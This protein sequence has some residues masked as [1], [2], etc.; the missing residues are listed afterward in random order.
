M[1]PLAAIL[2]TGHYVPSRVMTNADLEKIVETSDE[3]IRSRTGIRERRIAAADEHVSDMATYAGKAALESAG[4]QASE[5]DLIILATLTP[6]YTWPAAACLVQRKLGAFRAS[7]FDISA[8]CSGF[9]YGISLAQAMVAA[10]T[11]KNILVIGA[12]KLSAVVD[13]KDR[14]TCVLFGDGAG[15]VV[16]GP[17]QGRGAILSTHLGTDGTAVELLYQPGGGTVCPVSPE[18]LAERKHFLHMNGKEVYKFAVK[19]MGEAAE[20]AMAKAGL[21]S[22]D[23]SLFIPH[24]ANI[25]IIEAAAKRLELPMEKVFINLDKYGNTSA[26]SVG[27]ALDEAQ[28]AGRLKRGDK[29]VLVAFGAGLTWASAVIEW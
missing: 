21:K 6:D 27:I 5:L 10:G 15:A 20:L 18:S 8:A 2:G 25:R 4:I 26:A 7:A 12:E 16:V 1:K 19:V 24:Q 22:E 17:N 11:A 9:V 28:A 13:W 23:I 3:W 14:N 29:T